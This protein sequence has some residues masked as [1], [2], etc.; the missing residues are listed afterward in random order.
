MVKFTL[1]HSG[2]G[3]NQNSNFEVELSKLCETTT[4]NFLREY[5]RDVYSDPTL[6]N[7][8]GKMVLVCNAFIFEQEDTIRAADIS[9]LLDN[10][11]IY[12]KTIGICNPEE[13]GDA[14]VGHF[15]IFDIIG[16]SGDYKNARGTVKQ[17]V[18]TNNLRQLDFCVCPSKN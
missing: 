12:G 10:G 11:K 18:L 7:K 8:K 13:N 4:R 3:N 17:I 9:F 5:I 2:C 1:Y 16:G 14:K 6:T 15:A